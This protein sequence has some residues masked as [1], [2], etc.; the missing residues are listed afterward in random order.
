MN[1]D[2]IDFQYVA[3][4]Y[5]DEGPDSELSLPADKMERVIFY[6]SLYRYYGILYF[7]DKAQSLLEIL[8]EELNKE[9][10]DNDPG[11]LTWIGWGVEWLGRNGFLEENTDEVLEALDDEIYKNTLHCKSSDLS[12]HKGA[13]G[14]ANYFLAR[15]S[16]KKNDTHRFRRICHEECLI[17]LV[18][19]MEEKLFDGRN[20]TIQRYLNSGRMP[21]R[22][23]LLEFSQALVLLSKIANGRL[24]VP[25]IEEI[26]DRITSYIIGVFHLLDRRQI[27]YNLKELLRVSYSYAFAGKTLFHSAREEEGNK[28]F[29]FLV[30][31][32]DQKALQDPYVWQ[33]INRV[34]HE[35]EDIRYTSIAETNAINCMNKMKNTGVSCLSD[36]NYRSVLSL[37]SYGKAEIMKWDEMELIT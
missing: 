2:I 23:D 27:E 17:F 9:K 19:E 20:G 30:T 7:Q 15:H 31:F 24:Q 11:Y 36:F 10:F 8:W 33:V 22:K 12:V 1:I 13:L 16:N 18:D 5:L 37:L 26:I 4:K 14:K 6:S 29:E 34:I 3:E 32:A 21:A 25:V 28:W 35:K